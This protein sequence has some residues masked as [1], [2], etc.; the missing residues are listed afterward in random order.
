MI[1]L[2][3]R[4]IKSD[5]D[6]ILR[7]LSKLERTAPI[8]IRD[9]MQARCAVDYFQAVYA[10]IIKQQFDRSKW[11]KVKYSDRYAD[12]KKKMG[13]DRGYWILGSDLLRNLTV[14]KDDGAWYGGVQAGI[15]DQG[16]KS[17]FGKPGSPSGPPKEIAWYGWKNEETRPV[18]GP[19]AESYSNHGWLKQADKILQEIGGA[20][21]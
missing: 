9:T 11:S 6:R 10:N 2:K 7:A 12:W 20:W 14:F 1:K 8:K 16:G 13:W 5:Y 19:T 21:Q 17:W 3:L 18:F 15:M 4:F